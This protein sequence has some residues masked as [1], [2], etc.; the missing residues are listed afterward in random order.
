MTLLCRGRIKYV[1]H[2]PTCSSCCS[3]W[4]FRS[5]WLWVAAW[6]CVKT[7]LLVKNL[8]LRKKILF[9]TLNFKKHCL[10]AIQNST[11][12]PSRGRTVT[13]PTEAMHI[14]LMP[15]CATIASRSSANAWNPF[16]NVRS[17]S[18]EVV[19]QSRPETYCFV[20][21]TSNYCSHYYSFT[22]IT[23]TPTLLQRLFVSLS[24]RG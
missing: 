13:I 7:L 23:A 5:T 10:N 24:P 14:T 3:L 20:A 15:R 1:L 17:C 11:V 21:R 9:W 6:T 18:I 19:T 4:C 16:P 12:W 2:N 8:N 22:A